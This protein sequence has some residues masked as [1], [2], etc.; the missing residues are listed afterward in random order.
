[1]VCSYTLRYASL[2]PAKQGGTFMR[3]RLTAWLLGGLLALTS[4]GLAAEAA[5]GNSDERVCT[6]KPEEV[7]TWTMT[8]DGKDWEVHPATPAYEGETG[9]FHMSTAYTLP[10]GKAS[11]SLFRDNLDRDPK[12]EDISIHG[13]SL[14]YGATSRLEIFGN[15]GL[16]NR[17]NVDHREQAGFVNDFPFAGTQTV[18]PSW[19]TGV[20]DVKLGLKYKFLDDYLGDGVGL[21]L[22]G[23]VK[24]PTADEAKGLGTGKISAGADLVLS[25]SLNHAADIHGSIG[26]Q[27]NGD[28]DTVNIGNAFKWGVGLNVPACRI[29]Q[30]QA[31]LTGTSYSGA[32]FDQTSPL[33]LIVGPVVWIKPGI[34]IRPAISFNLNF[35]DRGLNSSTKS[36]TGRQVSIG[37]HPGTPCCQVYTPPPPLPPAANRP[38]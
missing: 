25:K 33:D 27:I 7:H 8:V 12:D 16:Q 2:Q 3:L 26:Y 19:Q 29:F 30:L 5:G 36:Y 23:F 31:E 18:A 4:P 35:N 34:F 24:I 10:K 21:A 17:V 20:G 32:S 13:L 15:I 6:V 37:F 22:R 1:M 14:G 38:P 28:P 9:L 11:F